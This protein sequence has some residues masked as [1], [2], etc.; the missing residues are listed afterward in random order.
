M[1][2][3]DSGKND[4]TTSFEWCAWDDQAPRGCTA[5][6]I[7]RLT[8][9]VKSFCDVEEEGA[10]GDGTG[11]IETFEDMLH[12]AMYLLEWVPGSKAELFVGKE[13]VRL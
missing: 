12:Y 13:V 5:G 7:S 11:A 8:H 1:A 9:F 4:F 3:F 2:W 6:K 10:G